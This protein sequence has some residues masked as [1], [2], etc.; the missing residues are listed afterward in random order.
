MSDT[1]STEENSSD[2]WVCPLT[3]ESFS[4]AQVKA[5]DEHREQVRLQL[6][7]E[8]SSSPLYQA[9]AAKDPEYWSKFSTGRVHLF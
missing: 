1:T 9:R 8:Y 2:D 4:A 6:V 3:G 5:W 7:A